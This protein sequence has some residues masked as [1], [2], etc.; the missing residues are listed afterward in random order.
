MLPLIGSMKKG[1]AIVV[2]APAGTGKTTL[3]RMLIDEFPEA[4]TQSISCTTRPPREGEIDGK[5]YVFLKE[6]AFQKRV[7]RGEFLEYAQVFDHHYGT[8]AE[9]VEKQR[10]SGKHVALVIDT[11]GAMAL[12]GK[13]DALF[14]FVAPPSLEVL[15]ERLENRQTESEDVR[16]KRLDW[17]AHELEQAAHYDYQIVND[18]L[19]VAYQVLKSIVIAEEHRTD[20]HK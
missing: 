1:F 8:L 2:S 17:A 14:I 7:K 5:D 10:L 15:K 11:Q 3:V 16:K 19:N 9:T 18:D 13:L 6:D 20:K 4:I 12:K